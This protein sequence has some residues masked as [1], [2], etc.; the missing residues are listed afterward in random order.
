M[1][2]SLS[3]VR[4]IASVLLCVSPMLLT[5]CQAEPEAPTQP[6]PKAVAGA[7]PT[8]AVSFTNNCGQQIWLAEFGSTSIAPD[9]WA[10]AP[11][12]TGDDA[13]ASGQSCTGGRC[14]CASDAD[15]AF[16]AP[17]GTVTATCSA[18]ACVNTVE[19]AMPPGWSGRF[20]ARTG[21]SGTSDSFV[22]ETGQCGPQSGGNIDCTAQNAAANQ[23]TLFELSAAGTSGTDNFDVSLVSGYNVPLT[24]TVN[25]PADTPTWAPDTAYAAGAQIVENVNG[26]NFRFTSGPAGTSGS[27]RPDFP[28]QWL[29][30]VADGT[31]SWTNT[32][33][34]CQ[35]SGCT[36][37]LLTTCPSQLEVTSGGGTLIACDAPANACVPTSAPCN[38]DLPY[39]Q[40]QNNS[41]T[42]DLFGDVLTFQSPN[43]GTFVCFSADDCP[44]GTSCAMS[45]TFVSGFELPAGAGVCTPVAQNG[46]CTPSDDGTVCPAIGFPFVDY[47][48]QTLA[49]VTANAQVCIPPTT[50]GA[51]DL[52]WNAA[53]WT[54]TSPNSC[55]GD[56]DCNSSADTANNKC[57]AAE[58]AGGLPQCT[59][60]APCSCYEPVPCS[61]SRGVDDGCPGPNQ[62]LNDVG[63]P[64]GTQGVDCTTETCYCGPQGVYS[65]S[66]GPTNP[67]WNAAAQAVGT[68]G[69]GWTSIFKSACPVAYAYQFDDPSS[70]WSCD[71]TGD[72]LV[73][74]EV[75][76]CL[77]P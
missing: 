69:T 10:L 41:G 17:A 15:C 62:C 51:G 61:S 72:A 43:A 27:S 1:P 49:N 47:Q 63:V 55:S 7:A 64:D 23:A 77:A 59:D 70:D 36:S 24:V 46:G 32:G 71:N 5:G 13:C 68:S 76:F 74:Y 9:N 22:C 37:D 6:A 66:C 3:R 38:G 50:S 56:S 35:D 19:L 30:S 75:Q 53:N 67:S 29:A 11:T 58:V 65:G 57:L 45:P 34:V 54:A 40:C 39:Y 4:T 60:G 33:P 42:K 26:D 21:C 20:W 31:T 8:H 18:G 12:C 16:G 44:A 14:T 25:L 48:C 73:G 2:S 52:W 28:D